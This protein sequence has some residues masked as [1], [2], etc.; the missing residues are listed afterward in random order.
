MNVNIVII[1]GTCKGIIQQQVDTVWYNTEDAEKR[2]EELNMKYKDNKEC[3][4]QAY[5]YRDIV[6]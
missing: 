2:V 1:A 3:D 5:C 4:L 6:K